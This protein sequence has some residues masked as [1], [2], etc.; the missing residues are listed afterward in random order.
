MLFLGW[1]LGGGGGWGEGFEG[2]L[3]HIP[4]K[5]SDYIVN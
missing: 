4:S 3:S 5:L 2:V 1:G